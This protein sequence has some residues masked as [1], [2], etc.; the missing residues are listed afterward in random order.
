MNQL[1]I[2]LLLAAVACQAPTK[3][4][5]RQPAAKAEPKA[6]LV[7]SS[8]AYPTGNRATSALLVERQTPAEVQAGQRY[9]YKIRLTNLTAMPLVNV[10]VT[11]TASGSPPM[12]NGTK[13]RTAEVLSTRPWAP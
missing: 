4:D 1:K 9:E 11:D 7:R 2:S 5:D 8:R 3:S 12:L 10:L 13:E 6:E